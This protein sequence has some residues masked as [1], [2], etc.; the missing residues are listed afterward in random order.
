MFTRAEGE[1]AD[2]VGYYVY[3]AEMGGTWGDHVWWTDN[4]AGTVA[5]EQWHCIEGFVRL[6]DVG[7]AN[8]VLRG[9]VDGVAGYERSDIRFRSVTELKVEK[10]WFD[11]YYGGDWV[12]SHDMAIH[13]DSVV[14]ARQR[15]G[16]VGQSPGTPDAGMP[17]VNDGAPASQ[18][19]GMRPGPADG[20]LSPLVD[21]LA[22]DFDPAPGASPPET[23]G[24][25]SA[26]GGCGVAG[27]PPALLPILCLALARRMR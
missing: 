24:G 7:A 4:T 27:P 19:D 13:F 20:G 18:A 23:P 14:L 11:I 5:H 10:F 15:V 6:N 12:P 21:Q 17:G 26:T 22:A 1:G 2:L 16:C 3:H 25:R 9:W 8:G